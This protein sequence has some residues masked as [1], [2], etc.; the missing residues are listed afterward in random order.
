MHVGPSDAAFGKDATQNHNGQAPGAQGTPIPTATRPQ[1]SGFL[2]SCHTA[3]LAPSMTRIGPG[4]VPKSP[5]CL[6][7][8]W[9][10][11]LPPVTVRAAL[12]PSCLGLAELHPAV[13]VY[14]EKLRSA[15]RAYRTV[16]AD[17]YSLDVLHRTHE[18]LRNEAAEGTHYWDDI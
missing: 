1:R 10:S 7:A 11:L 2:A 15:Q 9:S 13:E 5:H 18:Q 3:E 6:R 17:E 16:Q 14:Y 4:G 8:L 12:P